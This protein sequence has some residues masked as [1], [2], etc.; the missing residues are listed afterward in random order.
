MTQP[1]TVPPA[2][3]FPSPPAPGERP[4]Q[5]KQRGSKTPLWLGIGAAVVIVG[6]I[7]AFALSG[8]GSAP[9][10]VAPPTPTVV[11][12]PTE[13]TSTSAAPSP[14]APTETSEPSATATPTEDDVVIEEVSSNEDMLDQLFLAVL[15][16]S[17]RQVDRI[18]SVQLDEADN[19]GDLSVTWTINK[20]SS[21]AKL[22]S[23]AWTDIKR[24]LQVVQDSG[25]PVTKITMVGTF[26]DGG[27]K[28]GQV[29][30]ATYSWSKLK[31][32]DIGGASPSRVV[33]I[34][35]SFQAEPGFR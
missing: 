16:P 34:A 25:V 19:A 24:M 27:A 35:D 7:I 20:N 29:I 23:G 17:N 22:K 10:T 11:A 6:V 18:T 5:P 2:P 14:T 4:P 21:A 9:Q 3:G 30:R 31:N 1:P 13:V 26:S 8:S 32:V 28:E 33:A 12:S 15:G